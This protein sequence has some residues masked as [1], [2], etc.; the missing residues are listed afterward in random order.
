MTD[1]LKARYGYH[2]LSSSLPDNT[3]IEQLLSHRSIRH[4]LP[5]PVTDEELSAMIAAAQSAGSSSNL[6]AWSVITVRDADKRARLVELTHNQTQILEAPLHLVWLADLSR[7]DRLAQALG[8]PKA[9]LDY[10][11]SFLIAVVD[12]ALAAQNAV[13][14]AES[15]GL[16][17]NYIGGM[18]NHPEIIAEMFDLPPKTVAVFGL[19]VGRPDPQ[20]PASIKP[21][22]P[23][24]V[25][26]HNETYSAEQ[27]D[28][29]I[30]DYNQAMA[31]F[32]EAQKMN[33]H[34]SWAV[35]SVKR[36]AGP[37]TLAGRDR[38]VEALHHRGFKLK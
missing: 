28:K 1:L 36:L 29:G 27:A 33:V 11:D 38:L 30:D 12:A 25:V 22:L 3:V 4:Y 8:R 20:R 21:R 14:A 24:S 19:C 13:I 10:M 18:R 15:L 32:Y 16:G 31:R 37:E 23:Q 7:L 2:D 34:A 35:H 9:G 26:V 17:T 6:Q 5:D